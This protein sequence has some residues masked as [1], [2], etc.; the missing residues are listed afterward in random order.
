MLMEQIAPM[1]NARLMRFCVI[2]E[3]RGERD[4]ETHSF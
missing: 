3:A 1:T 4:S 2:A